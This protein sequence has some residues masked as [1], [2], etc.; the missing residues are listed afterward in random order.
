ML[1]DMA[2]N[3]FAG[4]GLFV[5]GYVVVKIISVAVNRLSGEQQ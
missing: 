1:S 4:L 3:L 5:A 2:Y